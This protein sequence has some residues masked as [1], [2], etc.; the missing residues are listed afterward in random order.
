MHTFKVRYNMPGSGSIFEDI[1]QAN[2]QGEVRTIM[3]A[4]YN[5]QAKIISI[6]I[7]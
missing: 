3:Q 4:K 2:N 5:G 6:T 1:I 7:I